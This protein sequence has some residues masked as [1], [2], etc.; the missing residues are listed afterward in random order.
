MVRCKIC[1]DIEG[2]EKFLVPKLNS[3]IKHFGMRKCIEA[4]PRI[5]IE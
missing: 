5:V 4:R 3:L 1:T 2:K